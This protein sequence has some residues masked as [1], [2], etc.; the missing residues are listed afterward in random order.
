MKDGRKMEDG[1]WKE[2]GRKMEDGRWK[3]WIFNIHIHIHIEL[4]LDAMDVR[5]ED[6]SD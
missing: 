5:G 6:E 2:D 4:G 1:R 3:I